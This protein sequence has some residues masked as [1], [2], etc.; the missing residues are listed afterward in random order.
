MKKILFPTLLLCLLFSAG[1]SSCKLKDKQVSLQSA[2][3]NLD[4]ENEFTAIFETA[5]DVVSQS[6][7]AG[8]TESS[9]LPGGATLTFTD[10]SFSD[11]TPVAFEIDYGPL[12]ATTPKGL[13]CLDGRYRAGKIHGT[14]SDRFSNNGSTIRISISENDAY[15][16]GNGASMNQVWGEKEI[17]RI[18]SITIRVTVSGAQIRSSRGTA[19]WN[20]N[21]QYKKILD[22]GI[23]WWNDQYELTG[24]ANGTNISGENFQVAI[25][26]PLIK[27]FEAG[28]Y[29]TFVSGVWILTDENGNTLT[30]EY[31]PFGN[32]ACDNQV[33]ATYNNLSR[34]LYLW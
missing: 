27:K 14:V 11:G 26:E 6:A 29:K 18:D 10:T 3:D 17:Q 21:R 24:N 33:K 30:L 5:E 15:Y 4:A 32:S 19:S 2:E 28:C 20:C 25:T 13:L 16:T 12:N 8:K 1:L 31:D 23:G 7:Y 34:I 9:I 22:G